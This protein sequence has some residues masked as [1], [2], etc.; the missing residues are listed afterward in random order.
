MK[1]NELLPLQPSRKEMERAFASKDASYDGVFYVAV[2]TTGIFCRPSC[3]SRPNLENVEFFLSVSDCFFAGY[4][5][6]KRCHPMEANGKPP[7]WVRGLMARVEAEPDARLK[8]ADLRGLGV[9]PERARR[10][11]QQH[12]GMSFAAWCRGNRLA[13][14]FMRLR[15]GA[16]LDDAAFDSG[17]E[18]HSGFRDAFVRV[19]GEAPGRSR[20]NGDRVV[21]AMV[22][23]PLGPLLAGATDQGINLLEYTDRGMLEHNLKLMQRRFGCAMVPGR[24]PLLERL[25]QELN[26]Y[27]QGDRRDFTLPLASRGTP[28]Q[29]KVWQ[30]LRRIPYGQTISYDELARRVGQPTAQ[31]AVA[32]ANGMN[33]VAILIPCHRVIGKDGSLTGYGGGLWRKRLLL[34]LERTGS[35]PGRA[36]AVEPLVTASAPPARSHCPH[37]PR[38]G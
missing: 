11:F 3:P 8:A 34:E 17:F 29:D 18:S 31:R 37:T 5:P 22:E 30:E 35:L 33:C 6:C 4:R 20:A 36:Q 38:I 2:K 7:E 32:S 10:W 23:T 28:F 26:E 1:M 25:S 13:G 21:M 24:H 19:F 16:T 27:F 12:Y 15:Q 9:T 14:A